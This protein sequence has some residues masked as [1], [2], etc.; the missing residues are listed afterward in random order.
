[1]Q[2]NNKFDTTTEWTLAVGQ[3]PLADKDLVITKANA[4]LSSLSLDHGQ[5]EFTDPDTKSRSW[6]C[7]YKGS[8]DIHAVMVTPAHAGLFT[9]NSDERLGDRAVQRVTQHL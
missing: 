7:V 9:F 5:F 8:T 6:A 2:W 4:A 1:M 3:F